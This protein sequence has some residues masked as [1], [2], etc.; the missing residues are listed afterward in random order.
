MEQQ[1][2]VTHTVHQAEINPALLDGLS[3]NYV[4]KKIPGLLESK[5]KFTLEEAE[6]AQR[7]SRGIALLFL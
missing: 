7:G 4:H 6:M 2:V 1:F 5:V 3:D